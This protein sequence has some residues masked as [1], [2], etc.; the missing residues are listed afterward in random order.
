MG[1]VQRIKAAAAAFRFR[2]GSSGF[3]PWLGLGGAASP[4][5]RSDSGEIVDPLHAMSVA[6]YFSAIRVLSEDI[7]KLPLKVYKRVER[8]RELADNTATARLLRYPNE[9]NSGFTLVRLLMI[10]CLAWGNGFLYIQRDSVG[11]PSGLIPIEPWRVTIERDLESGRLRYRV[12]M[13]LGAQYEGGGWIERE[14]IVHVLGFTVNGANGIS[15]AEYAAQS[16]GIALA[17]Q[18]FEAAFYRNGVR[19]TGVLTH[20]EKL[21]EEAQVRL[22]AAFDRANTGRNRGGSLVLEE[23]MAYQQ[24]QFSN[25]D[26]QFLESRKFLIEEIA[27][28][29]RLPP[30]KLG[31]VGESS[32][33]VEEAALDYL[34]S[35]LQMHIRNIEEELNRKLLPHNGNL[36]IAFDPRIIMH[37]PAET[38]ANYAV[39]LVQHGILTP[40]EA[41]DIEGLNPHEDEAADKLYAQQQ[42]Q[43]LGQ[44]IGGDEAATTT[45]EEDGDDAEPNDE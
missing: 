37:A 43:P 35:G 33:S 27:R 45:T 40:N 38:R 15:V 39:R 23:G 44:P 18:G 16:L 1:I 29:F 14:D 11:R 22:K 25:V 36:E 19:P 34:D 41:R 6:A 10:H 30:Y 8:G 28:W 31:H 17:Q 4:L 21:S 7:A 20:P 3:G 26:A 12:E 13:A 24:I 32:G 2:G 42:L 5:V 9:E